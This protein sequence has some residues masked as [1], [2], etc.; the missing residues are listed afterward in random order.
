M[1]AWHGM[2]SELN[3]FVCRLD[4]AVTIA[5]RFE[6]TDTFNMTRYIMTETHQ[7]FRLLY[8][9]LAKVVTLADILS[10]LCKS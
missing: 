3:N 9:W 7:I 5:K 6:R 1:A 8:G 10:A 4:V 2:V